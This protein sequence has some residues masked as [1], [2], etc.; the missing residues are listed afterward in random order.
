MLDKLEAETEASTRADAIDA[1]IRHFLEDMKTKQYWLYVIS[2][3]V[4]FAVVVTT[5]EAIGVPIWIA[6]VV[7]IAF[8]EI[9][10]LYR[11]WL[12]DWLQAEREV[13]EA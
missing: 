10:E 8:A 3:G 11:N 13:S 12:M 1:A 7:G 9:S 4:S 6:V 2:M 5:L